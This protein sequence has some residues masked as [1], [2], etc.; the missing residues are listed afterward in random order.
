MLAADSP[1]T[2]DKADE[3]VQFFTA[4]PEFFNVMK[5]MYHKALAS[6]DP[7]PS[8]HP[9][10]LIRHYSKIIEVIAAT[11]IDFTKGVLPH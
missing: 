2:P 11:N 5:S 7:A 1:D 4:H 10:N 6:R 9:D 8:T 3:V